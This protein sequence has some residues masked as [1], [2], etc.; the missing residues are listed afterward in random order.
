MK[1]ISTKKLTLAL[2]MIVVAIAANAQNSEP[3]VYLGLGTGVHSNTMKFSDIDDTTFPTSESLSSGVL[4]L[5]AEIDF[6]SNHALAVR[7]QFTYLRRGGKLTEIDKSNWDKTVDDAYYKLNS[8]YLDF[9][10]P[11]LFQLGND[12]S[13]VRPYVGVAPVLGFST[14]GDI[15]MQVDMIDRKTTGYHVEMNSSNMSSTYFAVQPMIGLKIH[16]PALGLTNAC[17]LGLEVSYELGITDTYGKE[18]DGDAFDVVNSTR[19]YRLSGTRKFH[20]FE[21]NATVGIP[22]YM[23][24]RRTVTVPVSSGQYPEP[25][26]D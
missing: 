9:R 13:A 21:L 6:L 18:K 7:P 20:G 19:N 1:E 4:S 5:F 23:S 24:T 15:N 12:K 10:V 22:L 3:N 2:A 8:G 14:G 25:Y 17:F 26:W 11:V 16:L